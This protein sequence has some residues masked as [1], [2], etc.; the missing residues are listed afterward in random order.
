MDLG[1]GDGRAVLAAAAREPRALVIGV[2]ANAASMADA[3]RRAARPARKGGLPNALFVAAGVEGLDSCLD[4]SVDLVTVTLPWGSLLLGAI[5]RDLGVAAAIARLPTAGGRAE[6]L[7]SVTPRDGVPGV[8]CLDAAFVADVA[9]RYREL[10]LS[11]VE[12]R[13]ATAGELADSGSSWA[14]RLLASGTDREPWRIALRAD[15]A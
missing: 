1:T 11:L 5:A 9:A 3:S 8:R 13:P 2:D 15:R 7:L 10:D 14:K 6:M 12:A 4:G